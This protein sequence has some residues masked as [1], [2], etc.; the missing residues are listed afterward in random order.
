MRLVVL[1]SAILVSASAYDRRASFT[2]SNGQTAKALAAKFKTLTVNSPCT[3][4]ENVCLNNGDFAKC[5]N[6]K[7]V[8]TPC[9]AGLK[10]EVLPLVNSAGTSVTCDTP[11]DDSACLSAT[12]AKRTTLELAHRAVTAPPACKSTNK[13]STGISIAKRIGQ[14]DL[15]AVAQSWQD[16]CLKSGGDIT[17]NT[18]CIT[19]AGMNGINALL[20]N[21]GAC[22]QQKNADAMVDFAKSKHSR[23]AL[24]T[25]GITPS[26][27]YCEQAPRNPELN[28]IVNTQ[29]Q[30]VDPGIF[31]VPGGGT[32]P[33]G[34]PSSCPFG[35]KP[36][37]STCTCK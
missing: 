11:A 9:G 20:V 37:V 29:L 16:L 15:P 3:D 6:G 7:F 12:G 31:S 25:N 19:L 14:I 18:P 30:G 5:S 32:V 13:R 4:G 17:T 26:T 27:P 1:S 10:C 21:A 22:D 2:K 33:F 35:Q 34:D 36:D 8:A 23:N 28:G 24:N